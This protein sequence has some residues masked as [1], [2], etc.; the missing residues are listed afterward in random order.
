M[1]K[2]AYVLPRTKAKLADKLGAV[3]MLYWDDYPD[4]HD[5]FDRE[6]RRFALWLL[7]HSESDDLKRVVREELALLDLA[8]TGQVGCEARPQLFPDRP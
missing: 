6:A 3:L 2:I 1:T 8:L 7:E 5:Y 4:V